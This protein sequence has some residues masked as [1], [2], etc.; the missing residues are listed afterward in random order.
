M[1]EPHARLLAHALEGDPDMPSDHARSRPRAAFGYGG[2]RLAV[3]IA[4]SEVPDEF[5]GIG[6]SAASGG[7]QNGAWQSGGSCPWPEDRHS[8][9]ADGACR[10]WAFCRNIA[11]LTP[12]ARDQ[13]RYLSLLRDTRITRVRGAAGGCSRRRGGCLEPAEDLEPREPLLLARACARFAWGA[14]RR[15]D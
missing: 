2:A 10:L 4:L 15:A 14:S 12:E 1:S 6:S 8:L 7:L 9:G 3:E 5:M 11:A 13:S